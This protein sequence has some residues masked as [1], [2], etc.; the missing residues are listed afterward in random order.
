MSRWILH[1]VCERIFLSEYAPVVICDSLNTT[2]LWNLQGKQM[3]V[4]TDAVHPFV[5]GY[6][7][8]STKGSEQLTGFYDEN[9][10]QVGL[11][12]YS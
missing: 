9:G 11:N 6:A 10:H 3:A 8:T 12:G 1:P 7:V 4:T 2:S 5:D